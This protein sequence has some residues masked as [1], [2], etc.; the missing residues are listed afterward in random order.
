MAHHSKSFDFAARLLAPAVRDETAVVYAYLRRVDDAIDEAPPEARSGALASLRRELDVVY[1][2]GE[3]PLVPGA[4]RVVVRRRRIPRL[5]LE[6]LLAGMAMDAEGHRYADERDLLRY[7]HRAAG[8]VGLI[9]CHVFGLRDDEALVP[10]VHLGWA[11]Q[12]TNI[13]RDVAEDWELGRRYLPASRYEALGVPVPE[14]N[15]GSFPPRSVD[16]TGVIVRDLLALA[17]DYYRSA[18]RGLEALPWRASLAVASASAIYRAIG[19]RIAAQDHDI[20][21]G[22]AFVPT[23]AKIVLAAKAVTRVG[24]PERRS[25]RTP[26]RTLSFEEAWRGSPRP[27][28]PTPGT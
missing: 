7:C 17:D 19:S 23:R 3:L 1:G 5:Y 8:V 6:E 18:N 2:E 28:P 13:C 10:A 12:L 21:R 4:F 27:P 11:M 16:A 9:M 15:G 22:R 26:G 25:V 24:L 14:P 20:T